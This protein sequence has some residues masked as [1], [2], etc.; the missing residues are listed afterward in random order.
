M[1]RGCN[2]QVV[3]GQYHALCY[4]RFSLSYYIVRFYWVTWYS[5][6][7]KAVLRSTLLLDLSPPIRCLHP[8]MPRD[9]A[10]SYSLKFARALVRFQGCEFDNGLTVWW[11]ELVIRFLPE[12]S[13]GLRVLSLPGCVCVSVN[14]E[15]VC[16]ITRHK[17]ELE[18]PNLDQKCKIFWLRSLL[19][20][21]LIGL[22]LPCQN[23]LYWKKYVYLHQFC[24]FEIFVRHVC[25]TVQHPTWLRTYSLTPTCPPTGSRHRLWNC[26]A[27]YLGE[28]IGGQ[29][30][31]TPFYKLLS[32]F[33][34]LYTPH[35]PTFYMPTF[36]NRRNNSK[37]APISRY[38]VQLSML[39]KPGFASN[40]A[41]FSAV[42]NYVATPR[43]LTRYTLV[44]STS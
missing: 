12:A 21:G 16:A 17:F 23:L 13:F 35:M 32:V 7:T 33:D 3:C 42:N 43:G 28:A 26:L 41:I 44:C 29:P 19:F 38:F 11:T 37:T 25:R 6:I 34:I 31:S 20:L 2:E 9:V 24:I 39:G 22:D 15:L 1:T 40:S 18:S 27:V 5:N 10:T 30:A 14:H 36:G 8:E 4:R